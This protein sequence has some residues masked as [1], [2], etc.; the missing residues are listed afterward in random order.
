[1]EGLHEQV[2][3]KISL[4]CNGYADILFFSPNLLSFCLQHKEIDIYRLICTAAFPPIS[5]LDFT[6][7]RHH[8]RRDIGLEK[9][10]RDLF[11]SLP[12]CQSKTVSGCISLLTAQLW[13]SEPQL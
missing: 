8:K 1:M 12:S 6:N 10:L 4:V 3:V 5:L 11:L 7:K 9:R 13:L 2:I